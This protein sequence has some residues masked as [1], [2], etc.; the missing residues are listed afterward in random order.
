MNDI[1]NFDKKRFKYF[2]K[3]ALTIIDFVDMSN[4][5]RNTQP[6]LLSLDTVSDDG[7]L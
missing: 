3:N 6:P 4:D 5:F 7:S 2:F 1:F